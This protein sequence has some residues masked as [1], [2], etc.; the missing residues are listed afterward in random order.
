MK[1]I[2]S[3]SKINS[4]TCYAYYFQNIIDISFAAEIIEKAWV[5][6]Y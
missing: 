2:D 4:V 1:A 6:I 3:S 5:R